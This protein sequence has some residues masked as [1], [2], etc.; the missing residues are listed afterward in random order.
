MRLEFASPAFR[1]LRARAR[2]SAPVHTRLRA[3]F[4]TSGSDQAKRGAVD[5]EK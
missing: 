3:A 5:E 1:P 2:I 4:A